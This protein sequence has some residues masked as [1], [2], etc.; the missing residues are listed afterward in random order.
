VAAVLRPPPAVD[1]PDVLLGEIL[2]ERRVHELPA[3]AVN[4]G[5]LDDVAPEGEVIA[6]GAAV[7]G[8]GSYAPDGCQYRDVRA[9]PRFEVQQTTDMFVVGIFETNGHFEMRD[10]DSSSHPHGSG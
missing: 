8:G 1:L 10:Y 3:K 7:S 2:E 5:S 4:D 9:R 6:A